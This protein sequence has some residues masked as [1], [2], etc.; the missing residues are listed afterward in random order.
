M[1][2]FGNGSARPSRRA[3]AS[4][5]AR[6]ASGAGRARRAATGP[7]APGARRPGS[8]RPQPAG[9]SEGRQA[10]GGLFFNRGRGRRQ[11]GRPQHGQQGQGPEGEGDVALPAGGA[12]HL[13]VVQ[14]RLLPGGLEGAL[15][16]PAGAGHGHQGLQRARAAPGRMHKVGLAAVRGVRAGAPEQEV[17]APCG[18]LR[19]GQRPALPVVE[20]GALGPQAAGQGLPVRLRQG[21]PQVPHRRLAE[22]DPHVLVAGHGQHVGPAPRLQP[23]AQ[24]RR[25]AVDGIA[26]HPGHGQLGVQGPGQHAP[27]QLRLG[28]EGRVGGQARGLQA[29]RLAGPALG[30]VQ[31]P[32][33]QRVPPRPGVGQEDPHLAVLDAPGRAAV[34]PGHPGRVVPCLRKPVSST[35][36]TPSAWPRCAAT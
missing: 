23:P 25:V 22:A 28:R 31:L 13:V 7:T 3:A 35:T 5:P 30:Q 17:A 6:P 10:A 4:S 14:P 26:R 20:A 24:L 21:R 36:A 11:R 8:G 9:A 2:A 19:L 16:A 18:V 27:G 32:V 1:R 12:A 29:R 15:D 34:L 33:H